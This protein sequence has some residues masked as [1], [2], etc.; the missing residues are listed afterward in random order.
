MLDDSGRLSESSEWALTVFEAFLFIYVTA[1]TAISF[2]Y[3]RGW[4]AE[5]YSGISWHN[6]DLLV[7]GLVGGALLLLGV[8][9]H[10][11]NA[12][13]SALFL[14]VIYLVLT[15][16]LVAT[17]AIRYEKFILERVK[18]E[19]NRPDPRATLTCPGTPIVERIPPAN[20]IDAETETS[21]QP[22][23]SPGEDQ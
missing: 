6:L 3:Y 17:K 10:S 1:T 12:S 9:R 4:S 7:R 15:I 5:D 11:G 19:Q 21:N 20:N 13:P 23:G 18:R 22:D 16:L 8:L 2:R 14:V